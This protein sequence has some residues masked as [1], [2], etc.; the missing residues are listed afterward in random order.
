MSFSS[1]NCAMV[2]CLWI[3]ILFSLG[4]H[5]KSLQIWWPKTT[6]FILSHLWWP[7]I[8]NQGIG[9]GILFSVCLG[10]NPFSSFP[11][12]GGSRHSLTSTVTW[13]SPVFYLFSI[14]TIKLLFIWF[15]AQMGNLEILRLLHLQKA[16]FQIG[17]SSQVWD[18]DI[19]FW[20]PP[21]NP[22]NDFLAYI[23][24]SQIVQSAW[25]Q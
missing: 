20:G 7:K 6:K 2:K 25:N 15:R 3:T 10:E 8:W 23:L 11:A 12:F 5:N 1:E 21:F 18:V 4:C 13:L 19:C 22:Q 24:F 9:R 16:L 14:N 17:L